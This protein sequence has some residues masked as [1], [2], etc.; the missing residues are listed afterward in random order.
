MSSS[1]TRSK[2]KKYANPLTGEYVADGEAL[3]DPE[4]VEAFRKADME[5]K[6]VEYRR[7]PDRPAPVEEPKH[8]LPEGMNRNNSVQDFLMVVIRELWR[9]EDKLDDKT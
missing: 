4:V 1:K 9:I 5:A 2:P 7:D 3:K 6:V 8:R